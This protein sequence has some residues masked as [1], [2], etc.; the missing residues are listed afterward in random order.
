MNCCLVLI[1]SFVISVIFAES[2]AAMEPLK[3]ENGRE[4]YVSNAVSDIWNATQRRRLEF[5][6]EPRRVRE[7]YD[8][9]DETNETN[10]IL[11]R[12]K[13]RPSTSQYASQ[14]EK[15]YIAKAIFAGDL[16]YHD[17]KPFDY[18][19]SASLTNSSPQVVA[20][21]RILELLSCISRFY[22]GQIQTHNLNAFSDLK[23]LP[24]K[25]DKRDLDMKLSELQQLSGISP[26]Q[27]YVW[28]EATYSDFS[29]GHLPGFEIL[30][31]TKVPSTKS[32]LESTLP[33]APILTRSLPPSI[34]PEGES[35]AKKSL[36]EELRANPDGGEYK[37]R[38]SKLKDVYF[39]KDN[40]YQILM[41]Q[42]ANK[43]CLGKIAPSYFAKRFQHKED[44]RLSFSSPARSSFGEISDITFLDD[45]FPTLASQ[46]FS[47]FDAHFKIN[48]TAFFRLRQRLEVYSSKY[49]RLLELNA[50][51][52]DQFEVDVTELEQYTDSSIK[53]LL[54][55]FALFIARIKEIPEQYRAS[56]LNKIA[57]DVL[58]ERVQKEAEALAEL[59]A[60]QEEFLPQINDKLDLV[61]N[62]ERVVYDFFVL[63]KE[64]FSSI[65][66]F[67]SVDKAIDKKSLLESFYLARIVDPV[68]LNLPEF[69][70]FR[71]YISE[72]NKI[73]NV[74]K[75]S[76]AQ[77]LQNKI[78]PRETGMLSRSIMPTLTIEKLR[79]T[80]SKVK[81]DLV[82]DMSSKLQHMLVYYTGDF[83]VYKAQLQNSH[84]LKAELLEK[85]R[86]AFE[87]KAFNN[88]IFLFHQ[89]YYS[90]DLSETDVLDVMLKVISP[91]NN[92]ELL[93]LQCQLEECMAQYFNE[94]ADGNITAN[95]TILTN[96]DAKRIR[97]L[98]GKIKAYNQTAIN[99]M[100]TNF[101][102]IA[103]TYKRIA[104][105]YENSHNPRKRREAFNAAFNKAI[106]KAAKI[107]K[108]PTDEE[109]ENVTAAINASIEKLEEEIV[110]ERAQREARQREYEEQS[111]KE[112]S[113]QRSEYHSSGRKQQSA[114]ADD[115]VME[116]A[117][118]PSMIERETL[119]EAVREDLGAGTELNRF[120]AADFNHEYYRSNRDRQLQLAYRVFGLNSDC[121]KLEIKKRY[122]KLSLAYHPDKAPGKATIY[123]AI[124]QTIANAYQILSLRF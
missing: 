55:D 8:A 115:P 4:S 6:R 47:A 68:F 112:R 113:K 72:L 31:P 16:V 27:I 11:N 46:I 118:E 20:H 100:R 49:T 95:G 22:M 67:V 98:I 123:Q 71:E 107:G 74:L 124:F 30:Y 26:E 80:L 39:Q 28:F 36:S 84:A 42:L 61:D 70:Q 103:T 87:F 62:M 56:N 43:E 24:I 21:Y 38:L 121:S 91:F 53:K 37:Q 59:H 48:V 50:S 58:Q 106:E 101:A 14:K 63:N 105:N 104:N 32:S 99:N 7:K 93:S 5:N 85:D 35:V 88:R 41:R 64:H 29:E 44:P 119:I 60:Q 86:L 19:N 83:Q 40:I 122:H 1:L 51:N 13:K 23:Y 45:D 111:K 34:F 109:K 15:E 94:G 102:A 10:I 96:D 110:R 69:K 9:S 25:G 66:S 33:S 82:D 114:P 120:G 108:E 117:P 76:H 54:E 116:Q 89:T 17:M 73:R 79:E 77:L 3:G 75:N 65:A 2:S 97:D 12:L 92:G 81:L 18:L 52:V 90:Y 57:Y 78:I